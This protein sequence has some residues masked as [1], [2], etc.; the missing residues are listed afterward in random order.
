MS[1]TLQLLLNMGFSESN[2]LE[3]A[4]K[5]PTNIKFA[6]DYATKRVDLTETEIKVNDEKY[7]ANQYDIKQQAYIDSADKTKRKPIYET[8]HKNEDIIK[9]IGSLLTTYENKLTKPEN[10]LGT[11]TIIRI[12]SKKRCYVL[13]VAHN[14]CKPLRQ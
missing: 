11:G 12:D 14:G 2:A 3:A 1:Q 5:H 13:T 4:S 6:I 7:E 8:E 9:C 10:A